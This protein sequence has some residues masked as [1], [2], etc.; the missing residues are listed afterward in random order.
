MIE[1]YNRT[2]GPVPV[3]LSDGRAVSIPSKGRLAVEGENASSPGL[4]AEIAKG[5]L[6]KVPARRVAPPVEAAPESPVQAVPVE[7]AP[8]DP[9]PAPAKEFSGPSP[10]DT[11]LGAPAE[12][13]ADEPAADVALTSGAGSDAVDGPRRGR[14]RGGS[15]G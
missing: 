9:A 10:S 15:A 6:V 2:Q 13:S 11:E 8:V 1:Y 4:L 5:H 7:A 14:R 12:I 3:S